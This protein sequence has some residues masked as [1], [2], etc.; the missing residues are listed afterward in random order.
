MKTKSFSQSVRVRQ[1]W[2]LR[3]R[4]SW[5]Q[6]VGDIPHEHSTLCHGQGEKIC[7][8]C[9]R[10]NIPSQETGQKHSHFQQISS[11]SS[12]HTHAHTEVA[13]WRTFTEQHHHHHNYSGRIHLAP[14][15]IIHSGPVC[16]RLNYR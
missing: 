4:R 13:F 14:D 16:H 5:R 3:G 2:M 1:R 6:M 8:G 12:S 15:K 10:R 11:Q 9:S 7:S